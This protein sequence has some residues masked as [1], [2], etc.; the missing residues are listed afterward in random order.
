MTGWLSPSG[1]L[2]TCAP[3]DKV[4]KACEIARPVDAANAVD[5]MERM[6]W[7]WVESALAMTVRK[8]TDAQERVLRAERKRL[9]AGRR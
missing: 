7:L 5:R 6:G 4:S 2:T 9:N 8:G 1:V 3:G